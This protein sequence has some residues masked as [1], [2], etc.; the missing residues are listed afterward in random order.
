MTKPLLFC[1]G[2]GLVLMGA[3]VRLAHMRMISHRRGEMSGPMV[4]KGSDPFAK[5]L[6]PVTGLGKC[7]D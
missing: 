2:Q 7:N 5:D 4:L 3:D 1:Q 6:G